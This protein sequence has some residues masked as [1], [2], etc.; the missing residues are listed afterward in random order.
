MWNFTILMFAVAIMQ[1]AMLF[2]LFFYGGATCSVSRCSIDFHLQPS[3][4]TIHSLISN[5]LEIHG[6]LQGGCCKVCGGVTH[7]AR[8][9][10]D[11]GLRGSAATGKEGKHKTCQLLTAFI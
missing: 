3:R 6:F 4:H 10:P 1:S 9:C 5:I 7:L 8:D 11:K 2:F